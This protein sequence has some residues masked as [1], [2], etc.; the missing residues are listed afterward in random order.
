M[1]VRDWER[2]KTIFEQAKDVS[3][4]EL[5]IMLVSLCGGDHS[6]AAFVASLVR[7][8]RYA[9]AEADPGSDR[10][11]SEGASV[12]G[13]LRIV[14]F[15]DR[16][17]MGEVYEAFDERLRQ[18]VALKTIRRELIRTGETL[19]RFEREIRMAREV[20]HP[21]LCR[22][23]DFL[24]DLTGIPC[25]T[26]ELIKGESLAALLARERP[27][28]LQVGLELIRQIASGVDALH[29]RGMIHRDL[30][31]SNIMLTQNDCG[32]TRVV[33]MDFGLAK[34][35]NTEEEFF[36]TRIEHQMG[37]PYFL[38]PEL[39]R[40][41]G[42]SIASDLYSFGLVADEMVT[43]S[44]AF[45]A[46]SLQ[47]LYFA[48]LWEAPIA[49]RDRSDLLPDNWNQAILRCIAT[50]PESRYHSA[51]EMVEALES[52]APVLRSLPA[53]HGQQ[54]LLPAWRPKLGRALAPIAKRPVVAGGAGAA[55]LSVAIFLFIPA[56][57][58]VLLSVRVYDVENA[59]GNSAVTYL[60]NGTSNELIRRLTELKSVRVLPMRSIRQ[61]HPRSTE[62]GVSV[63]GML[64][65]AGDQLRLTVLLTD[66]KTGEAFDSEAFDLKTVDSLQLENQ[67][68]VN[69]V[70]KIQAHLLAADSGPVQSMLLPV[71]AKL[72]LPLFRAPW[73][74]ATVSPTANGPAFDSYMRGRQLLDEYS[75]TS[76]AAALTYLHRAVD[77]DPN[78]ALGY[79]TLAEAQLNQMTFM[80][81]TQQQ[82]TLTEARQ[83]ATQAVTLDPSLAE[84]QAA[85]AYVLQ[86]EWDWQGAAT[87]FQ[88]ALKLK[89]GYAA[90]KR[91]YAGLLLQF[92]K[93][94]EALALARQ[95]FAED[96][97]DRGAIPGM[98]LYLY[99]AG[100][101]DEAI[102]FLDGQIG[103]NDM[104]GAR[105]NLGDALAEAAM[106]AAPAERKRLFERAIAQAARVT[107]I[108]RK[109]PGGV[110]PMGDEM[111]AHYF[112]LLGDE[113][114]ANVYFNRMLAE[115][116][117]GRASPAIV[118]WI[119]ALRGENSR[120]LDLLERAL[121]ARD[122]HLFYVKLFP[123]LASLRAEDRFRV[124]LAR[125]NL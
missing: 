10:V 113:T 60:C 118:A 35:L 123:A 46:Q 42:P 109:S 85:M 36:Q 33:L 96:P 88:T 28:P 122:R 77:D 32:G 56:G 19:S 58:P 61:V 66:D 106:N 34:L 116:E 114:R 69:T 13:R 105:H 84:A 12:A 11:F 17:A 31:P 62:K 78:F 44:R 87:H 26:M 81:D 45:S 53:G 55:L 86:A 9:M 24:E 117:N 110:T 7:N 29:Q 75:Q 14:R 74:Q 72:H 22:V 100:R 57:R 73:S 41:T 16:G 68:A 124:I 115:M 50:S 43:K 25:Y 101:Y 21:N 83:S 39:L 112:T 38:A 52:E 80:G 76:V 121:E 67:I 4:A 93:V 107:S 70:T 71:A 8:D 15:I 90:A 49:P 92:G 40:D 89:P 48:K 30:K 5:N 111:Y 97:Y 54:G 82:K 119:C 47:S 1:P 99:L 108:E 103:E 20:T 104:Q 37:A 65:G 91:R 120:A 51:G 94:D 2:I 79:A 6:M 102:Q 64:R 98:G 18:R 59:T 95:A 125:M 3:E 63:E 23:F 27:L